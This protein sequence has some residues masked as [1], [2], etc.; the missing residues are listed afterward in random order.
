MSLPSTIDYSLPVYK[1]WSYFV[2]M[3]TSRFE[4]FVLEME[5]GLEIGVKLGSEESHT[6]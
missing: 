1:Y 6:Y 2:C 5:F 3:K 4:I